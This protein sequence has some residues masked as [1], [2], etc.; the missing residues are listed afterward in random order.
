MRNPTLALVLG[1]AA[2]LI[3][4]ALTAGG[5]L[6]SERYRL[7]ER[8]PPPLIAPSVRHDVAAFC[9]PGAAACYD[10]V[11][12]TI[13]AKRRGGWSWRHELGHAAAAQML[14]GAEVAEF[15]RLVYAL[16]LATIEPDAGW[17]GYD[18]DGAYM[19]GAQEVFADAYASCWFRLLPRPRPNRHG[20][21][22]GS[23]PGSYNYDPETNARQRRVCARIARWLRTPIPN[24]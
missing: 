9:G 1:L 3:L 8:P 21:V 10:P 5:A 7:P 16:P 14:D 17:S 6:A 20:V 13:A 19:F 12:N 23:W 11:T 24:S 18:E 15:T 22:V 4:L 2:A